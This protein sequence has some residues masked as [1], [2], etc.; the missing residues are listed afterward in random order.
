[1]FDIATPELLRNLH[2]VKVFL[3]ANL[4]TR[5]LFCGKVYTV[6][7]TLTPEQQVQISNLLSAEAGAAVPEVSPLEQE[8]FL[9]RF[10]LGALVWNMAYF[11]AMGD[12][13]FFWLSILFSVS[14]FLLPGLVVLAFLARRRAW[15]RKARHWQ[16]FAHYQTVQQKWDRSGWYGIIIF[17]AAA[18]LMIRVATPYL[19]GSMQSLTGGSTGSIQEQVKQAQDALGSS[20]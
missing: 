1:M 13:P 6:R 9:K 11:R 8:S 20:N 3:R 15:E 4:S 7:M 10:S 2:F 12:M 5:S 16:G 19:Q 14:I 18:Y 17:F